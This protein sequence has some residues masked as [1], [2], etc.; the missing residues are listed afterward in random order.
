[1]LNSMIAFTNLN[2]DK[3]MKT[4]IGFFDI[5]GFKE[6]VAQLEL[7]EL[8]KKFENLF[9][10][11]QIALSNGKTVQVGSAS[12]VPDLSEM[13]VNC[14]HVSDS[15]IFWTNK[16]ELNDF[17]RIIEVCKKFYQKSL[18]TDFLIRGAVVYGE[19]S[20]EPG[21]INTK[22]N[23]I[24]GNF[25]F[26]G[27]GLVEA[28]LLGESLELCGC[29]IGNSVIEKIGDSEVYELVKNETA[30]LYCTPRKDNQHDYLHVIKPIKGDFSELFF[31]NR[32]TTIIKKFEKYLN[33]KPMP[34]S[35]KK[36]LNNTLKFFETFKN[37]SL[38]CSK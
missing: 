13:D 7:E 23:A 25:S 38:P 11:S 32:A 16:D 29:V 5:L 22:E 2:W 28:Y 4:Y 6:I 17:K 1:M 34:Q 18:Q 24:F 31:R 37:P 26:I 15:I 20:F 30:V 9:R 33:G 8:K 3:I 10:D 35:V 12:V 21:T 14:I 19:M 36:K 27:K